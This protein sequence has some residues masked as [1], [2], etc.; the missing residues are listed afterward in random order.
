MGLGDMEQIERRGNRGQERKQ[1]SIL[2]CVAAVQLTICLQMLRLMRALS[3]ADK[4]VH[5]VVLLLSFICVET[6]QGYICCVT[7]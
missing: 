7:W 2:A 6:D 3:G 1:G 5:L 4:I